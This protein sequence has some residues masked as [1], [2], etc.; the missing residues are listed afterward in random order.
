MTISRKG[1]FKEINIDKID[2]S[3][4]QARQSNINAN[5]DELA[6]SIRVQGLF[7]PILVIE[8]DENNYE[9]I[10]GQRRMR[11]HR[12]ILSKEDPEKYG[13]IFASVFDNTMEE[14]EKKAISIN[15]NLCQEQMT[16][17]DKISAVTACFN[18]FDSLKITAEKTGISYGR[19]S[20]YVKYARLPD[21]L[22]SMK[23]NGDISLSTALSTANLFG[24]DTKDLK[25]NSEDDI[26]ESA[27]E[28]E[29][30]TSSQKK[31]AKKVK[32]EKPE[33]PVMEIIKE[34]KEKKETLTEIKIQVVAETMK[35]IV[36][37]RETDPERLKDN[38]LAAS[39]LVDE[40][41]EKNKE[42]L[43]E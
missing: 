36:K 21:V 10:A 24:I 25:G 5:V 12:D 19:V 26:I 43:Q 33:K 41:L 27:K 15:E 32:E 11:A 22:K 14:W 34:I 4:A 40:G 3:K 8:I 38:T 42:K 16:E 2:T 17:D 9:L 7:S 28:T 29:K 35:G 37:Y 1:G 18:E 23:D 6:D 31:K 39:E 20:K 13:K 30:L